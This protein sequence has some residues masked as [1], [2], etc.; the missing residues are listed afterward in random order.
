MLNILV[1][2]DY[3]PDSKNALRYAVNFAKQT[4]S[5]LIIHHAMPLATPVSDIPFEQFYLNEEE[6]KL[7]IQ[8]SVNNFFALNNINAS[9]LNIS[10]FIN[11]AENA[12]HGIKAAFY[13]T[14]ADII[15]MGTHGASGI[16]KYI[17][18][19]NTA[20]LIAKYNMPVIAIPGNY[21]FEPIYHIV[22]ASD[23][24]NFEEELALMI[25][26]AKI[27]QAVLDVFYFDYA[28][29]E[30]EHLM[31]QAEKLIR[32]HQYKNI[33][34]TVNKGKLDQQLS[35]QIIANISYSNTQ[36]L[37]MFRGN[38]GWLDKL[39]TGSTT[40]QIVMTSRIPVLI[41]KKSDN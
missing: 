27:F 21:F 33:K 39:L 3:S 18:G 28:T 30:S 38:Q 2:L 34:I 16:K 19:S 15:I 22:F 32:T 36:L 24:K 17:I 37:A 14:N 20:N 35:N 12:T 10:Y 25:P 26:I 7:L 4:Q 6:E 13:N 31:L 5:N 40:Q 1:P 9:S 23:L 8:E 11:A 41:V 29:D